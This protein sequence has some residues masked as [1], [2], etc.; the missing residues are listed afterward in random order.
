MK[1]FV[2]RPAV[3]DNLDINQHKLKKTFQLDYLRRITGA[4]EKTVREF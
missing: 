1:K 2:S 4:L 3:Y